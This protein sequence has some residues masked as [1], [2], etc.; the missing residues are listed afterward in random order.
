MASHPLINAKVPFVQT[1]Y[2][3]SLPPDHNP[4]PLTLID[5]LRPLDGE[6]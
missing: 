2:T 1:K 3:S 5:A 4:V 6:R